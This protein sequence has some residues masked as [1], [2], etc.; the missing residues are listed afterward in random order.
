VTHI[1]QT[2]I[3]DRVLSIQTG[4]LANQ[5]GAAVVV[6][7]NETIVLVTVC[8][9]GQAREGV[10]F[11]PLTIDYEERL[12]AA[13]KIPGGYFKREGRPSQEAILTMRLTDRPLRPLF[14]KNYHN[15]VQ[16]I[17]TVLS[18]DQE[19]DPDSLAI[20]GAS[21][22]LGLSQIPFTD[23][24]AA[25]RVGY[26]DGKLILNP[27]FTQLLDSSLD[28]IV[29]GT[30]E[31]VTM[32]EAGANEVSEEIL[33]EAIQF[34]QKANQE[35]ISLQ[36]QLIQVC[37]KEK[38]EVIA[39]EK[40]SDLYSQV[41]SIIGDR[42][43]SIFSIIGKM[44]QADLLA[45]LKTEVLEKLEN[46]FNK[47]EIVEVFEDQWKRE[48]REK[49]LRNGLR[50][51]GRKLTEVR[52]ISSEVGVLPRPHGSG[53]FTRG[54]TQVLTITTLGSQGEGQRLNGIGQEESKRFMHHYNF[55]PFS[56]GEVRRIGTPG[57]REIGH[58]A[59]AE[60]ALYPVIPSEDNFPY[61]IRLVS[62]VLSSNG[63]SSM[64]SV[65]GSTLSLMD[66]G[67]PIVRPVAGVAMG[68]IKGDQDN[69]AILTD[70]NGT[71][72][73]LGDMDFKVAG[74]TVGI[75]ALQMDIK[76]TGISSE[77][78]AKAL[79]QAREARL[80]I[81]E[82]MKETIGNSRTELSKYAPRMVK[83]SINPEKIGSVIGPKGKTIRS[84]I[85]ET[86]T[87]VDIQDDGSIWIGSSS[88]EATKK[89]I[90]MIEGLTREVEAG[91]IYTGKVT[92]VTNFGAFVEVIPGK[93]GLVHISK[94]ADY[95]VANV[96]DV[97]KVGDEIMVQ[98]T[99]I[100]HMGRINLSRRAVFE[101]QNKDSENKNETS[102]DTRRSSS[103][104]RE[105]KDNR[106]QGNTNRSR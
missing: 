17:I 34:G 15:D 18:A 97:V 46:S 89:A 79:N 72:D 3:G 75:T 35:I 88:E 67:V 60:R 101:M 16:I 90:A 85:D 102:S 40:N 92:R 65:C 22:A 84:I 2:V 57:R 63:S 5:A 23:L 29:A 49:I 31:A 50:V 47:Q 20:V 96:E 105:G 11:L 77:I 64:A 93:E 59:L 10:D 21:S 80:F 14:P 62:E 76:I 87:T 56:V 54:E 12:Y 33:L 66:A 7:Y 26:V 48:V 44:E 94:L 103:H 91:A 6:S 53:L 98:V 19:N 8:V 69:Y 99:D 36:R 70:I 42:F 45:E 1:V 24:I 95:R 81:L 104:Y 74:T 100:D 39:P 78:M 68:L 27:T 55:P 51:D 13:G 43:S 52:P 32:V 86:K 28:I 4:K 37:G 71:E 61:T 106:R 9:S 83:I 58:G 82:K 73:H 41:S 30:Y 38:H 25:S